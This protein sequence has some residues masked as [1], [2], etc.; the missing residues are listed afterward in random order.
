[1][2]RFNDGVDGAEGVEY[3]S[4]NVYGAELLLPCLINCILLLL[5]LLKSPFIVD[6][7][8]CKFNDGNMFKLLLLLK[9][10]CWFVG[11]WAFYTRK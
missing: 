1:M 3:I 2:G 7:L 11:F 4:D 9:L 5:L 6:N 8:F 10:S